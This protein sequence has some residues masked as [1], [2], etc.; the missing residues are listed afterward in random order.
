M[1]KKCVICNNN[2]QEEYN[3]LLGTILKVKNEK[4]KNE[5]IHVCSECQKKDKW[6]ETAKIKAA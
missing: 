3:K 2:I 6:I 5:F 4:G 1:V